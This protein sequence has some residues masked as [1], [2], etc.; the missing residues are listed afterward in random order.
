MGRLRKHFTL[1]WGKSMAKFT[2][3]MN[4]SLMRKQKLV[5]AVEPFSVATHEIGY[6]LGIFHSNQADS[7]MAPF[8]KHGFSSENKHELLGES[9]IHLIQ[10]TCR[11]PKSVVFT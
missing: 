10:E 4:V 2:L 1:E 8:Y 5:T 6:S 7:V 9:D 11:K 3:T